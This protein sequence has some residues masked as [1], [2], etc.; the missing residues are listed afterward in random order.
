MDGTPARLRMLT[1]IRR[2]SQF[3][4]EYSSRYT[5]AAMPRGKARPTTKTAIKAEP[6]MACHMPA[7][8]GSLELPTVRNSRPRSTSTSMPSPNTE[9]TRSTSIG[10]GDAQ[11]ARACA[12]L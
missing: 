4:D 7:S 2:V 8:A 5:A 9:P 10:E 6:K 3:S 1:L 12:H 11:R